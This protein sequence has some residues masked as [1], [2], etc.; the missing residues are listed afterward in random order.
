MA[1]LSHKLAGLML[2]HNYFGSHLDN[3][4]QTVNED[5]GKS[6]FQFAGKELANVWSSLTLD[7]FPV[8]A[9]YIDPGNL[10]DAFD[11][12]EL[13]WYTDHVRESQYL[14]QIVKYKKWKMFCKKRIIP[15]TE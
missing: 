2:P 1:P 15:S 11:L 12:P 9:E 13:Q 8:F 10:V 4:G 3:K 14:L 6:N 7:G 5:L